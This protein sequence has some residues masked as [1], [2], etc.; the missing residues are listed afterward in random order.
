MYYV[1]K[2]APHYDVINFYHV[3][4]LKNLLCFLA[5]KSNPSIITYVKCDMGR[6]GFVKEQ[7]SSGGGTMLGGYGLVYY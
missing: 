4:P 3:N 7:N 2:N 1:W 5:K 6:E